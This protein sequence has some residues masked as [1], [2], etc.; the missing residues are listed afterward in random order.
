MTAPTPTVFIGGLGTVT[1]DNLNTFPQIC[2]NYAQ[3]RTFSGLS[4]MVVLALGTTSP[5]DGGQGYFYWNSTSVATDNNSTVIVPFGNTVGAWLLLSQETVDYGPNVLAALQVATNAALGL[6]QLTAAGYV[7]AID[8]VGI[9]NGTSA[10]A[11]T[12]GE[13]ISQDIPIGGAV[14][15]TTATASDIATVTLTPGVW[16]CVGN[17]QAVVSGG[18][19]LQSITAWLSETSATTPPAM[20]TAGTLGMPVNNTNNAGG[21][22]GPVIFNVSVNTALHLS[23][24]PFFTGGSLTGY[25]LLQCIRLIH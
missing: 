11:G 5:D 25:G 8:Q 4:N 9:A 3:M 16:L 22:V 1:A 10:P 20:E 24:K 15:L 18:A 17:I 19:T 2:V 14:G 23:V 21:P 7:P 13:I 12:V 6:L